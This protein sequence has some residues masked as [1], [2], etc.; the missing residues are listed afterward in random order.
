MAQNSSIHWDPITNFLISKSL[1]MTTS[2]EISPFSVK[3]NKWLLQSSEIFA[4]LCSS[5][6]RFNPLIGRKYIQYAFWNQRFV[7]NGPKTL[8][9][10]EKCV[11]RS[12]RRMQKKSIEA[13]HCAARTGARRAT[14]VSTACAAE[15]GESLGGN[16]SKMKKCHL[17]PLTEGFVRWGP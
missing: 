9:N 11:T 8:Q 14:G 17:F 10:V 16:N 15:C 12:L 4:F 3:G 2:K 13:K 5:L 1:S 6:C 7:Y